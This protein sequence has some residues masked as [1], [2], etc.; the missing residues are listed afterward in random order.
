MEFITERKAES[1]VAR[2]V[3]NDSDVD[4]VVRTASGER[5]LSFGIG[6]HPDMTRRKLMLLM[7]R[8]VKTAKEKKIAKLTLNFDDLFFPKLKISSGEL[9]EL[10]AVNALMANF[11]FTHFKTEPK[12]GFPDVGTVFIENAK[13]KEIRR[14][15]ERGKIIG[16]EVNW[17]RRI[18]NMPGGD[19]TPAILAEH[20]K[21]AVRDLPVKLT[22]LNETALQKMKMGGVLAVGKGSKE[23]PKF[24]ILE[25]SGGKKKEAPVVLIG[26]GVTFDT[27]GINLKPSDAILGMNMDMSGGAA[28]IHVVAAAARLKLKKNIVA[29][30]PAVENM[31]SGESYRPGDIIRSMSGK[32]IEVQNTDAEGRIILADALTYAERYHPKLVIDVATLT[33]AA[34]VALGERAAA[35]FTQD[36]KLELKLRHMGEAVGD[37]VWPLPLWDEYDAE[38]ESDFGDI[39]NIGNTRWGGAIT[40]AAF[41]KQFVNGYK[42]VH[43]DIAPRMTAVKGE[44][45]SKGA[46]GAIIR[47][48][49]RFLQD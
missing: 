46:A 41:L 35:L 1:G 29:L 47:L 26:K 45:L 3:F 14:G 33:G 49:V 27:G 39:A 4:E 40:A 15:L 11:A 44:H 25:Y 16:E 37:F 21:R 30:I 2:V 43:F 38:I 18:S 42:W 36:E 13:T 19:M 8:I 24:I 48:L 20:A 31:P 32:M 6:K 10:F 7:R 28:V 5:E 9:A 22:I 17:S 34:M 12:E 23:K